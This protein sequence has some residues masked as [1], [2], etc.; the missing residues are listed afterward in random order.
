MINGFF[1]KLILVFS[2]FIIQSCHSDFDGDISETKENLIEN[3]EKGNKLTLQ[4]F[5]TNHLAINQN[6]FALIKNEQNMNLSLLTETNIE[7][8][9]NENELK[10]IFIDANFTQQ[11]DLFNLAEQIRANIQVFVSSNPA[12]YKLSETE[13]NSLFIQEIDRQLEFQ[14]ESTSSRLTCAGN[15]GRAENRCLRNYSIQSGVAVVVGAA[16]AGFGW[17]VGW[18]AASGMFIWCLEDAQSDY[19]DCIANGGQ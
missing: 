2:I 8:A 4:Q 12:F 5:V 9:T 1:I 7:R 19:E 16:T 14:E 15:R 6:I 17:L 18:G 11:A 10:Q 13:R 3:A